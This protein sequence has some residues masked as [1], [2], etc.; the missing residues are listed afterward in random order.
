MSSALR[1]TAPPQPDINGLVSALRENSAESKRL[2]TQILTLCDGALR[3]IAGQYAGPGNYNDMLQ[4]ARMSCLLLARRISPGAS[5]FPSMY[6][7]A[8]RECNRYRATMSGDVSIPQW[9]AEG[10]GVTKCEFE[11]AELST[12]PGSSDAIQELHEENTAESLCVA[13]QEQLN[14]RR[15][16]D[17]LPTNERA[18]VACSHGIVGPGMSIREIAK[19]RGESYSFVRST[20]IRGEKKLAEL[21]ADE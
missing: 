9:E 5:F 19:E 12:Q 17:K 6:W 20:L 4:I 13:A 10:R 16:V 21:L 7:A 3:K 15:A 11:Y 2:E 8:R 14:I 18:I 1:L